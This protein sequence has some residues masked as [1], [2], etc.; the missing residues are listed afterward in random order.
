MGLT[1]GWKCTAE[2]VYEFA[3]KRMNPDTT[4]K[5]S[6]CLFPGDPFTGN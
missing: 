6:S 2:D 5:V 4:L 1:K 3:L